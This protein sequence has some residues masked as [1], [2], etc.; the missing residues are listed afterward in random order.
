MQREPEFHIDQR[1]DAD[2]VVRLSLLGELDL[3]VVSALTSRLAELKAQRRVVQ[4]DLSRLTF[5]DSSGLGTVIT[6]VLD[7]RRDGWSLEIHRTLARP[8]QRIVEISG[9]EPYLWPDSSS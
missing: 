8:V 7:A 4:L 5:M 1:T 2:G 3:A 9:A 6:A